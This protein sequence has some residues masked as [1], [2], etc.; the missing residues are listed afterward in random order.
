VNVVKTKD[1]ATPFAFSL[2]DVQ[3]VQDAAIVTMT[4]AKDAAGNTIS[5]AA[6]T[7]FTTASTTAEQAIVNVAAA[8]EAVTDITDTADA[9]QV[10]A[11]LEAQVKTA[12]ENVVSGTGATTIAYTT[13][14]TVTTAVANKAPTDIVLKDAAGAAITNAVSIAEN[15][16]SLVVVAS[17]ATTDATV[18]DT[19]VYSIA[20]GLDGASFDINASTGAL[21]LKVQPDYETKTSYSVAVTST[22]TGGTGKSVT[23]TVTV[24]VTDDTTEGGAF[25]ISTDTVMWTDYNP[26]GLA[27]GLV[28]GTAASDVSHSVMTSTTGSQVSVGSSGYGGSLNLQNLK[29]LFD[30]DANTVGKSPNLHFT[31]DT[32]PTGSG[33][34]TIKATIIQGNDAT[35]SGTESEISVEVT[36][37]YTGDGTTATLTMPAGGTGAVSYTTAAGTTASYTVTNVDADAF[38]ITAANAATGD[39]AVLSVKMAALY[40]VFVNSDLG[41]PDMLRAGDYSIALETT[42][43]LQ[44]YA[45][46]TVTKFTGLLEIADE[47]SFD[48]IVGT[49]GADTITGTSAAEAIMPGA[50]KDTI[51]TGGGADF[52]ILAAGT[53]STTLANANTVAGDAASGWTNG[54]DKFA[55]GGDLTFSDLTVAA[56][57]TTAGDTNI[58]I[59]ATG[60]YLMTVTGLAY[61]YITTDDFV[62]TA[63]IV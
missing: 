58:S 35:R 60:E 21:S 26:A 9:F 45:N 17:M 57:T 8:V 41:A 61:G 40:D 54:T 43:P 62:S 14:S 15:A 5:N 25:G 20:A 3:A 49:D 46:E 22:D 37:A 44:N 10:I 30:D 59:T 1:A 6:V 38:S 34:A 56:D 51:S 31:L 29:N 23:E 4:S 63:D 12:A 55:L 13:N 24:S 16:S 28:A 52:I 19:H 7:N 18:G 36:V 42:L 2:A 50:G 47:N 27:S 48:S 39:A 33:Q 53:G 32:V 11:A